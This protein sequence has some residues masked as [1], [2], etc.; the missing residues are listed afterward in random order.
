MEAGSGHLGHALIG[1]QQQIVDLDDAYADMLGVTRAA[2]IGRPATDFAHPHERTVAA[3]FLDTAWATPGMHR[4]TLRH[5]HADGHAIWVNIWASR[6]GDGPSATLVVSCRPMRCL[7]AASAVQAQW[8]MALM[9][10]HALDEGKRAFGPTLIGNPATEILLHT[11]VAEAE[12]RSILA[13]E[14]VQR[15]D[16]GWPLVARW[17][18]AL[19]DADFAETETAEPLGPTSPIRLSPRALPLLEAVFGSVVSAMKAKRVPA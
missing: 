4:A 8:H 12:A 10:L 19:I 9:L 6:L 13:E 16:V 15:I 5:V 3:G 1:E 7:E 17:L 18:Q 11:Y 14:F 2:A